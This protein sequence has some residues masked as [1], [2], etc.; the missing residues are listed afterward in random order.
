MAIIKKSGIYRIGPKDAP[1]S[2]IQYAEGTEVSDDLEMEYV[3]PFPDANRDV[4][5]ERNAEA[6]EK[7]AKAAGAPANKAEAAPENKKA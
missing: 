4:M 1:E 3:E 7:A 2:H 5:A 6:N